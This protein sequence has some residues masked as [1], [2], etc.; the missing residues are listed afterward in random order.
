MSMWMQIKNP[1]SGKTGKDL[2]KYREKKGLRPIDVTVKTGVTPG[3]IKALEDFDKPIK[4]NLYER[5]KGKDGFEG[6]KGF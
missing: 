5:L 1:E 6:L 4:Q 2:K 3:Y